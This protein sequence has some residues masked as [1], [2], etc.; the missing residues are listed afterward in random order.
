MNDDLDQYIADRAAKSPDFS[1]LVATKQQT[2]AFDRLKNIKNLNN[3]CDREI[4]RAY[5]AGNGWK[6][7]SCRKS[8]PSNKLM[9][10]DLSFGNKTILCLDNYG[11][12]L[13]TED[14]HKY[15]MN[16]LDMFEYLLGINRKTGEVYCVSFL[17]WEDGP[18]DNLAEDDLAVAF[19]PL[20][21]CIS[22]VL[23]KEYLRRL[24]ELKS[25]KRPFF[26]TLPEKA[27]FAFSEKYYGYRD[28]IE[29]VLVDLDFNE[30]RL[31]IGQHMRREITNWF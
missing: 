13:M 25:K 19:C 10:F 3:I 31:Q 22:I 14:I 20:V 27:L 5:D 17:E 23:P 29:E 7:Y 30:R 4:S 6:E 15:I 16:G 28:L 8:V 2:D 1:N 9:N 21:S 18:P 24:D 26:L 11:N 12:E